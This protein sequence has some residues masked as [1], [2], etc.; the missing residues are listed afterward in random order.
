MNSIEKEQLRV[1]IQHI[2][3]SGANEMRI[4]EMIKSFLQSRPT[5]TV[6]DKLTMRD[7]FAKSAMQGIVSTLTGLTDN[8][9]TIYNDM[10]ARDAYAAADAMLKEREL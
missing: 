3:A 10:I 9:K 4:F 7:E 8:A 5:I 6:S 1:E 2:F